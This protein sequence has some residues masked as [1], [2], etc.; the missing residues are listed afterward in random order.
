[1]PGSGPIKLRAG[2][3]SHE[4]FFTPLLPTNLHHG[5]CTTSP[6]VT[7]PSGA[8]RYWVRRSWVPVSDVVRSMVSMPVFGSQVT[9]P[10]SM[11]CQ[12]LA[13]TI[14]GLKLS[15]DR[16]EEV[17]AELFKELEVEDVYEADPAE[18]GADVC[19]R[20]GIAAG[21]VDLKPI[22]EHRAAL[23]ELARSHIE[24][25]RG[26]HAPDEDDDPACDEP[27]APFVHAAK[28]H[29]PPN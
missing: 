13:V 20:L 22:L 9:S 3:F 5:K 16:R 24:A 10:G 17:P 29:G 14:A 8:T 21:G 2:N 1:M 25:L 15:F 6:G 12:Q 23:A 18:T 19:V 4:N 7:L 28:A 26:S 11:V 27:A